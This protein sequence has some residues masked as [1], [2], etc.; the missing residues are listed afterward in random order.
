MFK[1]GLKALCEQQGLLQGA[2]C[3]PCFPLP[4][5]GNRLCGSCYFIK[6]LDRQVIILLFPSTIFLSFNIAILVL[7]TLPVW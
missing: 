2:A 5:C 7:F 1:S 4:R 6:A 3:H